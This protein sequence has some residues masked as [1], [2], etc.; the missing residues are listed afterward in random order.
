MAAPWRS[1]TSGGSRPR[2]A[3]ARRCRPEILV[4]TAFVALGFTVTLGLWRDADR[5]VATFAY[6]AAPCWL[7]E[8][9]TLGTLLFAGE[10][11]LLLALIGA[12][13]LAYRRHP[14]RGIWLLGLMLVMT[15]IEL[16]GKHVIAQPSPAALVASVTRPPCITPAGGGAISQAQEIRVALPS[17]TAGAAAYTADI[18]SWPSGYLARAT[19][20]G[21]LLTAA[22]GRRKSWVGRAAGW[23]LLL[24]VLALGATRVIIAWHWATDVVGGSLL[25][26]L[27]AMIFRHMP[28]NLTGDSRATDRPPDDNR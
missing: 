25:G 22:A 13:V 26:C 27:A 6:S 11:S 21:L 18:G 16:A 2:W 23:L 3:T 5:S 4:G 8:A 28:D 14:L 1:P 7:R 19:Y 17:T 24:I 20:F 9:G 15:P 12:L 10:T